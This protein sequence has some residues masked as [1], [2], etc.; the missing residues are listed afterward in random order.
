MYIKPTLQKKRA[1]MIFAITGIAAGFINGLLGAGGGILLVWAF[2]TLHTDSSQDAIRDTFA[3]TLTA[4]VPITALSAVLYGTESLPD[5]TELSPLILPGIAGGVIGALLLGKIS[6]VLLK[7]I[8][9]VL[10]LY[11]GISMVLR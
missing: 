1:L 3:A 9:A 10:I 8:F 5:I 2:S 11:S 4:I 7:K 6:T